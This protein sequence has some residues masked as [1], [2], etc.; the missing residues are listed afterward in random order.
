MVSKSNLQ[1]QDSLE[2]RQLQLPRPVLTLVRVV[3]LGNKQDSNNYK[4]FNSHPKAFRLNK[5]LAMVNKQHSL[6]HSLT[7]DSKEET[8]GLAWVLKILKLQ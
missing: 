8:K 5:H 7:R 2:T 6:K 4:T 1:I 3:S